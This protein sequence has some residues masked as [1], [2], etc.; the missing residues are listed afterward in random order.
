MHS[1]PSFC[2]QVAV[3]KDRFY[4]GDSSYYELESQQ[5]MKWTRIQGT[6][7]IWIADGHAVDVETTSCTTIVIVFPDRK[8][9]VKRHENSASDVA[10]STLIAEAVTETVE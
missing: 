5:Q 4:T 3:G 9:V 8:F 1:I 6:Y 7:K 2:P 10:T